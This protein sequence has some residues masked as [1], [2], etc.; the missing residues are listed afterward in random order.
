MGR[1]ILE[2]KDIACRKADDRVGIG[3]AGQ[4]AEGAQHR[5]QLFGS[6]IVRNHQHKRTLH[7]P[8]Q[9]NHDQSLGRRGQSGDTYPP[10]A[11]PQMGGGAR[12]AGQ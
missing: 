7:R 3:G 2:R 4:L 11:L 12:E 10:R 6:A 5:Q 8:S 9:Q 1:Q